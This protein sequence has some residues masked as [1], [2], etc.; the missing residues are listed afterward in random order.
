MEPFITREQ[1]SCMVLGEAVTESNRLKC[2]AIIEETPF[3]VVY[4]ITE[5][6]MRPVAVGKQV[7]P[8]DL[9]TY[10]EYP[11]APPSSLQRCLL[12]I[13]MKQRT[14]DSDNST[15]FSIELTKDSVLDFLACI[16]SK[17]KPVANEEQFIYRHWSMKEL[18][19]M[20]NGYLTN[21]ESNNSKTKMADWLAKDGRFGPS[22]MCRVGAR[23][24]RMRSLWVLKEE[25]RRNAL[26]KVF[27]TLSYRRKV[28][29]TSGNWITVGYCRKSKCNVSQEQRAKLIQRMAEILKVKCLCEKVHVLYSIQIL[30]YTV[31]RLNIQLL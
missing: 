18:V 5:G 10:Q 3:Q 22:N 31:P 27:N 26:N 1:A 23:T 13:S 21:V 4:T 17:T 7:V 30:L 25:H 6:K 20:L 9:F 2:K 24:V 8:R 19:D 16:A 28:R 15:D 12:F 14:S 11:E 29:E